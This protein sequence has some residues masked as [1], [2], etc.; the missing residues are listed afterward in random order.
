[1]PGL[2]KTLE[3]PKIAFSAVD[4]SSTYFQD[5]FAD[6]YVVGDD[7]VEENIPWNL[8]ELM[9]INDRKALAMQCM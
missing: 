4:G 9:S 1:M 8:G 2:W 7:I 5:L 3:G 6:I